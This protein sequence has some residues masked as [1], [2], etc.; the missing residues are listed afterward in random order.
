MNEQTMI[1]AGLYERA[2]AV[3]RSA[4]PE[5]AETTFASP[6]GR[7]LDAG[8]LSDERA[9]FRRFPQVLCAA[10]DLPADGWFARDIGGV[11]VLATRSGEGE[12][13]AFL[14]VCRHR[15]AKLVADGAGSGR[16][17][18]A[19]PYHAWTYGPDG[20]LRG[21]PQSW[22]FPG[23]DKE[24]CGLRRLAVTERAGL[25]WVATA[26]GIAELDLGPL[27]DEL[28][29]L[30]FGTHVPFMPRSF[31][32]RANWKLM[33]DASFEGYHFK[34]AH[35]D[36]IAGMF[37]DNVQLIDEH[38]LNRRL[39]LVR[40][41]LT[42]DTAAADFSFR[43]HGNAIYYFFP[44]TILL[45][46]RD[47]AQVSWLEPLAPDRTRVFDVALIPAAPASEK[48][49]G[50][51]QRNVDLYRRTL[52]EDYALMESMQCTMTSGAN[53]A[54]TFGAFEFAAARFHAQLESEM[55]L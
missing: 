51:W 22:G 12:S 52:D 35:R 21:V 44:A 48:A 3:L 45:V 5:M 40:S 34:I 39:Y 46:Q 47:H 24:D 49:Q 17:A 43:E 25:I 41:T 16:R 37:A 32:L 13:R 20:A 6:V 4:R 30:G 19:C 53:E 33:M 27:A 11:P 18:F 9:L 1:G 2:Q 31:E 50:H 55:K 7:Y 42:P 14:N 23:L 54:L 38:G 8:R 36:T 10:T 29:A 15:G 28:D 26:P